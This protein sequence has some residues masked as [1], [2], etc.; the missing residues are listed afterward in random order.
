M[1]RT[2]R[3]W[4]F[5]Y[6]KGLA[7]GA[8]DVIPGV[9]G[10]TIAF[11]SGIY[12]ELVDSLRAFE[13][14]LLRV[15]FREGPL[16]AWRAVNGTFL[17]VLIG[18][19]LTSVALLARV[20][21]HL[22]EHYPLPVWSFFFGLVLA[23]SVLIYR[24]A[25]DRAWTHH[26]LL[27]LGAAIAAAIAWLRPVEVEPDM[28]LYFLAACVAICAMILPG[29]SGSFMLLL[30]GM[31]APVMIAISEFNWPV[32]LVFASGCAIGLMAF[33]HLL[34][35]LLHHY[36]DAMVMFLTGFLVGS[37]A[38]VW[39]WKHTVSFYEDRHGVLKPLLREN[40]WPWHYADLTGHSP[41]LGVCLLAVVVGVVLIPALQWWA[42]RLKKSR[43]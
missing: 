11:I 10:G 27:L 20:V 15:L 30:M 1:Q 29:I 34:S 38:M 21:T 26:L 40:V 19:I 22:L 2:L 8:A 7:M 35:W 33:S 39:P 28:L 6:V 23:S 13:P 4:L 17:A 16:A 9:S 41:L 24:H 12:E 5:L 18:G 3:D 25:H 31:Y 37:L 14:K 32:L 42:G 36:H 43:T